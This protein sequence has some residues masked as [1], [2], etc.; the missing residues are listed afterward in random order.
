MRQIPN[1][2][3]TRNLNQT[4]NRTGRL[5]SSLVLVLFLAFLAASA[6]AGTAAAHTAL[7][8][9]AGTVTDAHG[10]PL[11]GASVTIQTSDGLQ[12][13][14]T[15]TGP[16]GRFEFSRWRPGQYDVRAY[17]GGSF[18]DWSKRI[19]IRSGKT[20]EIT[21][22]IYAHPAAHPDTPEQQPRP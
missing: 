10:N 5:S 8:I 17:A 19:L 22:H 9:L 2:T 16:D 11:A 3:L 7:G 13:R 1:R 18:S 4:M 14:A 21:L 12:P 15:H 20:T 6:T